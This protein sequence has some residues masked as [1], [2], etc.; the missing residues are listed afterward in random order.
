MIR[1]RTAL[2][3][4]GITITFAIRVSGRYTSVLAFGRSAH[5]DNCVV[6]TLT[7]T[8][9]RTRECWFQSCNRGAIQMLTA[10]RRL[11]FSRSRPATPGSKSRP[12]RT[13]GPPWKQ[14]D[15]QS[16][17]SVSAQQ[18]D[19]NTVKLRA[20]RLTYTPEAGIREIRW[21]MPSDDDGCAESTPERGNVAP[22]SATASLATWKII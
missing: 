13:P 8:A 2:P 19:R 4:S 1:L 14:Q 7:K 5:L 22:M 20:H 12:A 17:D 10:C 16:H 18:N 21:R 11:R 6:V 15:S 9:E 3:H